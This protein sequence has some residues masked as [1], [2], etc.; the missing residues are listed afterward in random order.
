MPIFIAAPF[1]PIFLNAV[2]QPELAAEVGII[3]LSCNLDIA[4]IAVID[5][6]ED[7]HFVI[8]ANLL[9]VC[10]GSISH[11][12]V[13]EALYHLLTFLLTLASALIVKV[14]IHRGIVTP[15]L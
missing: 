3:A 9:H 1:K 15:Y 10:I 6:E 13:F 12:G 4:A 2:V 8:A 11:L 14:S 7:N 5:V